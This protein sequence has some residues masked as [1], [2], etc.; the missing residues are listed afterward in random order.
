MNCR[1]DGGSIRRIIASVAMKKARGRFLG[2]DGR[3]FK[4]SGRGKTQNFN[5]FSTFVQRIITHSFSH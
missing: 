2:D 3:K 1:S 5:Y 4:I